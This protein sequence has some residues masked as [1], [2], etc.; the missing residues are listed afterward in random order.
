[1]P[2]Y[3]MLLVD[4]YIEFLRRSCERQRFSYYARMGTLMEKYRETR[5][6]S[7]I[8]DFKSLFEKELKVKGLWDYD[9]ECDKDCDGS[10]TSST[11]D[12]KDISVKRETYSRPDHFEDCI[13]AYQGKND[14][15]MSVRD[16]EEIEDYLRENYG[17]DDVITRHDLE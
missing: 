7:L 1:M 9:E 10:F 12:G 11:I 13:K 2:Q 4:L 15:R 5:D 6:A 14:L 8:E 3:K 16:I 17:E